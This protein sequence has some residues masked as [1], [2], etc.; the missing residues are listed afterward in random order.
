MLFYLDEDLSNAIVTIAREHFG[1][2]ILSSHDIGMD[3]TSDEEQLTYATSIGRA[4]MTNNRD[5]FLDLST[6]FRDSGRE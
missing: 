6:R 5:D 2:D 3:H 1:L 4:I